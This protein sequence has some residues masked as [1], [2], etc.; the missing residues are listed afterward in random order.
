MSKSFSSTCSPH[1]SSRWRIVENSALR[2]SGFGWRWLHTAAFA[3][4]C[5]VAGTC[6]CMRVSTAWGGFSCFWPLTPRT[7][8][9]HPWG[10]F[11]GVAPF[12]ARTRTE[13]PGPTAQEGAWVQESGDDIVGAHIFLLL[14]RQL[15]RI[16]SVAF[17]SS[18]LLREHSNLFSLH[19]TRVAPA[20]ACPSLGALIHEFKRVVINIFPYLSL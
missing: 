17:T 20:L 2:L 12:C 19:P 4:F 18:R 14:G 7:A 15:G 13:T 9:G 11:P 8:N 16:C 6:E 5:L 1:Q 3:A 10:R